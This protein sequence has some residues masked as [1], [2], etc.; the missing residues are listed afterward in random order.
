[1]D[2]CK[3]NQFEPFLVLEVVT[4]AVLGVEIVVTAAVEDAETRQVLIY[5]NQDGISAV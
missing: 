1:M 2:A 5:G 3:Q 4:D